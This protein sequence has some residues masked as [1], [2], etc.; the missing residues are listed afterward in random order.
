M[1]G[2]EIKSY[3]TGVL[4]A[5]KHL[6]KWPVSGLNPGIY[7]AVLSSNSISKKIKFVVR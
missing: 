5:G 1:N 4:S 3:P 2:S 7:L 6:L